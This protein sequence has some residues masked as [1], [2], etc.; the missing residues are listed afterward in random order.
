[1]GERVD[2]RDVL[3]TNAT[4]LRGFSA[5]LLG[6]FRRAGANSWDDYEFIS[7]EPGQVMEVLPGLSVQQESGRPEIRLRSHG[8]VVRV[9]WV[10]SPEDRAA[11]R[12]ATPTEELAHFVARY[13]S[14]A[15]EAAG[16][17]AG[18]V[19]ARKLSE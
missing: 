3:D 13:L 14:A 6:H 9:R 1:M 7:A 2:A 17:G 19:I 4:T 11:L 18:A 15:G 8:R 10:P 12:D 16:L 5:V